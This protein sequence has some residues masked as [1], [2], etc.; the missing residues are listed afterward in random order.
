MN[1]MRLLLLSSALLVAA[2]GGGGDSAPQSA[3]PPPAPAPAPAPAS[4]ERNLSPVTIDPSVDTSLQPHVAIN[5]SADVAPAGKLFVFLPGTEA[6]PDMY[7]LILRSGASRG[8]HALGLNYPNGEAVGMLC[9]FDSDE[10]CYWKVRREIVDGT[11]ESALVDVDAAN[12]IA[13]RLANAIAYLHDNYPDEGWEQFL[14][15][16]A[17][18]WSKIVVAGH[19]QGGGHAGVMAKLYEMSRAVYFASPADWNGISDAPA[20][21]T[22]R[23]NETPVS[24]Q[25]GFTHLDDNLVPYVE[26][27]EIWQSMGI[28][29]STASVDTNAAPFGGTHLLTTDAEPISSLGTFSPTHGATIVD[30]STPLDDD[31]EPLYES[32]WAYL[33]FQ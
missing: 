29:G 6:V 32:V 23:A 25:F 22:S 15:N 10:D 2:C 14:T 24:R 33:C 4:V 12:S 13:G 18:D 11:D 19:S 3:P 16:G 17:V 26:L 7:R 5:P 21:W 9:K 31:D 27:Q 8:F 30:A 1:N 20:A 28:T